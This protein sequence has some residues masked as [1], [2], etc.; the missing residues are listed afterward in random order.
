MENMTK[1][2]LLVINPNA[3]MKLGRRFLPE[4]ISILS[5]GGYLVSVFVTSA[6]GEA[7]D[8]TRNH[9]GDFDLVAACGGDGTLNEVIT[10]LLSGGHRTP[11]GYI[12]CGSTNDFATGLSLAT[13]PL[14]ACRDM[15]SGA[16]RPLDIGAFCGSRYFSY[17]A[18][19]GAF[20][21]VSYSTPQQVKNIIGHAAYILEGIRSLADIR[22]IHLKVTADDQVFENDYLFGAVC[23]ST[24]LGGVLKLHNSQVHMNDGLF[25]SLLIPFPT[26]L[27]ALNQVLIALRTCAY[28]DPHLSFIR[29]SHFIFESAA[30]L[31]WT[32]DGEEASGEPVTV[33][34]NLPGAVSLRCSAQVSASAAPV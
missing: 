29:A 15:L 12:P 22:P 5:S 14:Q 32:L 11:L 21:S 28:Q 13:D 8:I 6:R 17:T 34:D 26:D 25:E 3:G 33:I 24:S 19:F 18:S 31:P 20:T 30:G 7:V 1:K 10:G 2:L 27:I 16:L 23:N 4:M 9:A